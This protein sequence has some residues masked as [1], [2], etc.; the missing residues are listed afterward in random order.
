MIVYKLPSIEK[1][2]SLV[3]VDFIKDNTF[4]PTEDINGNWVIF[5]EEVDQCSIDWVKELSQ[6]E[7]KPKQEESLF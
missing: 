1:K 6:I 2:D 7:Y 3:G 5:K 4:N